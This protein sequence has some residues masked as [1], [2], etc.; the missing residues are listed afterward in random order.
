MELFRD[1]LFQKYFLGWDRPLPTTAAQWLV[2]QFRV[3]KSLDLGNRLCVLPTTQTAV[4][5]DEL[6]RGVAL[7]DGLRYSPPKIITAGELPERLYEP[8]KPIA[9]EFEQ[10]LA[11]ARVL[12]KQ[13]DEKLAPLMPTLPESDSFAPWLEIAGTLRRLS[14]DLA[15]HNVEFADVLDKVHTPAERVRWELLQTLHETYLGELSRAGL[16]DPFQQRQLAIKK[17][18]IR[19]HQSLVLIGTSDLNESI[20]AMVKEA[21]GE[22]TVLIAAPQKREHDFDHLGRI[23]TEAFLHDELPLHDNQL[24]ASGDISDQS[25]VAADLVRQLCQTYSKKQIT[26]GLTDHSQLA[27]VEIELEDNSLSSYRHAGWT[28][29]QTG[30]GKLI[31]LLTRLVAR[32]TWQSLSAFVRHHDVHA[33]ISKQ[34]ES[35][36]DFL[37]DIDKLLADHFPIDVAD[38]LPAFAIKSHPVAI[39]V[40]DRVV[41]WLHSFLPPNLLADSAPELITGRARKTRRPP[42]EQ[43]SPISVWSERL[44]DWL[45]DV[46]SSSQTSPTDQN[47]ENDLPQSETFA[48]EVAP[49]QQSLLPHRQLTDQA[50]KKVDELLLRFT[51]LNGR[52]DVNVSPA[53]AL[54]TISARLADLRV[55]MERPDSDVEPPINLHGWLDLAMD[56]APALIV[57]GF[58]HPFVPGA[59][60]NDPFLPGSLRSELRLADNDRRYAR[61][62]YAMHLILHSRDHVRFVVGSNAA[63]GSPTPPSRLLSAAPAEAVARR[64]RL[65]LG[66]HAPPTTNPFG[67][68]QP[69]SVSDLGVPVVDVSECP[70]DSMSVTA[71][72][73]YLECPYRFYLRHVL[74]LKPLDDASGELAANQF[75][76]LV[77]G[78]LEN[79]GLS[80]DKGETSESRIYD[81]LLHHLED[82]AKQRYGSKVRSAVQM[83]ISQ[84]QRRLKFVAQSQAKRIGEGW[85][86]HA[87]EASVNPSMGAAIEVDGKKMGLKGRFDRIDFHPELNRWAILDYKT[88]GSPPEKKHL[89]RKGESGKDNWIDLQL[90]LYREMIPYLGIEVPRDEVELG[91]F[92]VSD[93]EEET[94]INLA[95]FSTE[96]L[97]AASELIRDCIRN[98]FA[99]KF[100]P[101]EEMVLY[102]DYEMI[103][104]TGV[105]TRMLSRMDDEEVGV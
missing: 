46:Y 104:Q 22:V 53:M 75:G 44:R 54:E 103:L 32:P 17:R 14:T 84:A 87:T 43:S 63:D 26:V 21:E 97:D 30:P 55:S 61:D 81:A 9:I 25:L 23:K 37:I 5:L 72:K 68:H 39:D 73:S 60:T 19:F 29:A 34:S 40:R 59:V 100:E 90:P 3:G 79:F 36:K 10:T 38:S 76:D 62:I 101:T 98:I 71:F 67:S 82:Y 27:P 41:Q 31:Q 78:A 80:K 86:I 28:V 91:Y 66:T 7:Q 24:V 11:W 52:L 49:T 89:R 13:P 96:Q 48:P 56:D 95:S 4:R 85:Q 105:P 6:L 15:S 50:A 8:E 77:H 20:A 65:L 35:K 94:K 18:R 51:E 47:D 1:L 12:Q 70:I 83:Q 88:H 33:W 92:N 93:K 58:N 64:I 69:R 99:C 57:V 16:S 74:G 42:I 102:D 45:H 2:D